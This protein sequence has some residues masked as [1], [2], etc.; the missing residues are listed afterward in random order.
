MS[1]RDWVGMHQG[2]RTRAAGAIVQR[3]FLIV[4]FNLPSASLIHK[5]PVPILV[6]SGTVGQGTAESP[7][8]NEID[9]R[10]R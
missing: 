3:N 10:L 9:R 6:C 2:V 5:G 8:R 7:S 1:F 4:P